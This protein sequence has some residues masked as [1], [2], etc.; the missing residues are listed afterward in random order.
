PNGKV[1]WISFDSQGTPAAPVIVRENLAFPDGLGILA[2]TVAGCTDDC[3]EACAGDCNGSRTVTVDEIVIGV[4]LALGLQVASAC[5]AVDL[6]EDGAVTVNELVGAVSALLNGC[7][8][9]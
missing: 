7:P 1:R 3:V 6:D 5:D 8:S 9:S 4:N 2:G